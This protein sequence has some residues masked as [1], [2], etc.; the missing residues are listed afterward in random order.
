M[1]TVANGA[2]TVAVGL[3]KAVGAPM[4]SV[5]AGSR[6]TI[7]RAADMRE[8]LGGNWRPLGILA[9]GARSAIA[10]C[11]D[12]IR[13]DHRATASLAA[14][15]R[16]SLG[17]RVSTPETNL[18]LID[19]RNA[20]AEVMRSLESSGVLGLTLNPHPIRL[21]LHSRV[22]EG[23]LEAIAETIIEVIRLF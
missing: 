15:L 13:R 19:C 22:A 18:I 2:D 5:L 9:A 16:Q 7:D 20:A 14:S 3:N 1:E 23:D 12:R 6:A 10:D 17:P 8:K 4:G 11:P 21:V